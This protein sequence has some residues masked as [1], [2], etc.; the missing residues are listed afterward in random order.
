[1]SSRHAARRRVLDVLYEADIRAR[2]PAQVLADQQQGDDP[3]PA[4]TVDLVAGIGD[5]LATIDEMI[6]ALARG[7][8]LDRMPVI[9]RNILR[10][11]MYELHH[12]TVPS[13]VVIDEAVRLA[14]EL[15][16]DDSGRYVNGILARAARE[17]E[18]SGR[19]EPHA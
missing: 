18:T 15:S 14:K 4:F 13:A 16:T 2:P 7:W 10:L 19:A 11:G 1:M 17:L 3:A 8:T 6:T 9:D 12:T 5:R